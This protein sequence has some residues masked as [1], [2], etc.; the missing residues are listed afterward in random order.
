[1]TDRRKF[2]LHGKKDA[3]H[4]EVADTFRIH[5]YEVRTIGEGGGLPDLFVAKGR[6][7]IA[8]EIK[9]PT[10]AGL[11]FAQVKFFAQWP[12]FANVVENTNQAALLAEAPTV[13]S[14][15]GDHR[16]HLMGIG[17]RWEGPTTGRDQR[18]MKWQ[19]ITEQ[20]A[21]KGSPV[22]LAKIGQ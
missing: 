1:V 9:T 4:D 13:W 16:R 10:S 11:K 6:T 7:V 12:G 5:G 3:N 19:T 21:R 8:V 22:P 14:L 2:S 20:L 18:S 17:I 15:C